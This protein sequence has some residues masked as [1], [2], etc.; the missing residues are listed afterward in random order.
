MRMP[1]PVADPAL[2]AVPPQVSRKCAACEEEEKLQKEAGPHAATDEAP[3]G[4]HEVL[5]SPGQPL[6]KATLDYFEPRFGH[7]FSHVRVHTGAAAEQSAR[8]VN[9]NAYTVGHDIA[10]A[11]GLFTPG[12]TEGRRLLAHELAH[13]V[14]RAGESGTTI[15][16]APLNPT[17]QVDPR[18]TPGHRDPLI[19]NPA[20][21]EP[22]IEVT[23][24]GTRSVSWSWEVERPGTPASGGYPIREQAYWANFEVD[25]QGVMRV[26]ARMVSSSGQFRAPEWTLRSKFKEALDLFDRRGV[27]VTAFEAEWGYMGPGEM[28]ANLQ[29]F[30][31][32]IKR[33]KGVR[34]MDAARATPSGKVALES[35]FTEVSTPSI[36]MEHN[37]A[38]EGPSRTVTPTVRVRFS[39]PASATAGGTLA[40]VTPRA[41]GAHGEVVPGAPGGRTVSGGGGGTLAPA[42]PPAGQTHGEIDAGTNK[43]TVIEGR[44]PS[45]SEIVAAPHAQSTNDTRGAME[46]A[47][48]LILAGQLSYVRGAELKKAFDALAALEPAIEQQR[49]KGI[50]VTVTVIAEIPDRPD[51]AALVTGVGDPS[52]VVRFRDMFISHLSLPPF[53]AASTVS[54]MYDAGGHSRD[55]VGLGDMTLD[56]QIRSQFGDKYPVPGTEPHT[57]FHFAEGK[58]VLPGYAQPKAAEPAKGLTGTWTPEFRQVFDGNIY[59]V[60]QVTPLAARALKVDVDASGAATPRMTLGSRAYAFE[61]GGPNTARWPGHPMVMTGRFKMGEGYPPQAQWYWSSFEYLPKVDALLEWAHGQDMTHDRLW[62]ALFLWRRL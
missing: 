30:F 56:Q 7:D 49:R 19:R 58:Q 44:G 5:C 10:F 23:S 9:A 36:G 20:S 51:V 57:G 24:E 8:A 28:S 48:S 27:K 46:G 32:T 3:A 34:P 11:A 41:Q 26:S 59:Q 22:L 45:V 15:Q 61:N 6:D 47:W 4:V 54:T 50:D 42:S 37:K 52:Q 16:R 14:Q 31:A 13:V 17:P 25:A 62:D 33:Q 1:A 60:M 43:P 40:P 35:G 21:G 29:S 53:A 12:T 2:S 38:L 18:A 39:R 55:Y